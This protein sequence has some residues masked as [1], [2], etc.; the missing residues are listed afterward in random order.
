MG[1]IPNCATFLN[2]IAVCL[3]LS[4]P[5]P[6]P[7]FCLSQLPLSPSPPPHPLHLTVSRVMVRWRE[8][9]S[10][11]VVVNIATCSKFTI[12]S[13]S[14][15]HV[16]WGGDAMDVMQPSPAAIS[17]S[18]LSY[19]YNSRKEWTKTH[20]QSRVP[21][22]QRQENGQSCVTCTHLEHLDPLSG[23]RNLLLGRALDVS[24]G[25]LV[26]AQWG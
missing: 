2:F 17:R 12:T 11:R 20:A 4:L 21:Q 15:A 14:G 23:V 22:Q 19:R 7:F 18:S 6:P 25:Y 5:P 3:S 1:I 8:T 9:C 26:A 10:L 16:I 13:G 24:P